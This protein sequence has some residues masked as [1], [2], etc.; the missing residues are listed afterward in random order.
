MYPKKDQNKSG[1]MKERYLSYSM[2]CANLHEPRDKCLP[3]ITKPYKQ[4]L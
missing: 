4:A 1:I 3:L 2:S